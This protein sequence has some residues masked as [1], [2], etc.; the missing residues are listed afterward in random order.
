[1]NDILVI[2]EAIKT[3][4]TLL[5]VLRKSETVVGSA[6]RA[7]LDIIQTEIKNRIEEIEAD[8]G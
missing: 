1:M 8:N 5:D 3:L 4:L 7:L 6:E 2:L